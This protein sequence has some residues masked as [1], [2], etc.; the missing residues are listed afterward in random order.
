[1]TYVHGCL[2]M[3]AMAFTLKQ[4]GH[5]RVDVFYDK[6]ST[7]TKALVDVLGT[8]LLLI[9]VS[10]LILTFSL[11]YVAAS[12]SIKETSN[13]SAGI[14]FVYLLKS[15]LIV[16]PISLILQGVSELL[17]NLLFFLGKGGSTTAEKMELL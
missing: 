6:F 8:L 7:R 13:E 14:P 2:F 10:I 11:D 4:G 9:P 16:M 17:K 3:L 12:W 15:L 5:V 1:M